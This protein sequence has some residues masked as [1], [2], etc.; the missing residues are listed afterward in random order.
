MAKESALRQRITRLL[1]D[2]GFFVQ[3][4]ESETTPGI[5]DIYY[6]NGIA[7]WLELKHI[8]VMPLRPTTSI[9]KSYNHELSNEQASWISLER[10]YGGRADILVGYGRELFFVPGQF[11]ERFNNFTE[12][13]LRAF[14]V[15][16]DQLI[17]LLKE[18][19]CL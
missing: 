8:K 18:Q 14:T 7:G 12:P 4:I 2:Y 6:R 1:R 3:A 17:Q 16:K 10:R 5:P 11:A 19:P 15:T 9:F 13:D